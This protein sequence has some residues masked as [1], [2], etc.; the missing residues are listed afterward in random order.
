MWKRR[1]LGLLS[2]TRISIDADTGPDNHRE[3]RKPHFINVK[4]TTPNPL[5]PKPLQPILPPLCLY[6]PPHLCTIPET[7]P[8]H[9]SW[10]G[11]RRAPSHFNW[12][13]PRA[14]Q[15][16]NL[17]LSHNF[18]HQLFVPFPFKGQTQCRRIRKS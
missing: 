11:S 4:K 12:A 6:P 1:R 3:I 18:V 17:T 14:H 5:S 16:R 10:A 7:P 13:A 2:E 15:N 8:I 9:P